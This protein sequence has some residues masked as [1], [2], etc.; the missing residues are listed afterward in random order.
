MTP[1]GLLQAWLAFHAPKAGEVTVEPK[2]GLSSILS[3]DEAEGSFSQLGGCHLATQLG[4][5][6][7][8]TTPQ[9]VQNRLSRPCPAT[10]PHW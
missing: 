7:A 8:A 6:A 3:R 1:K 2:V 9:E 10:G 4:P 5:G